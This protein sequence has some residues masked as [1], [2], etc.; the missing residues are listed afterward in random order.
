MVP[1][2]AKAADYE[3][4]FKFYKFNNAMPSTV[5][6]FTQYKSGIEEEITDL[7]TLSP[8]DIVVVSPVLKLKDGASASANSISIYF[9]YD[10]T[11]FNTSSKLPYLQF[12][13]RSVMTAEN[14]IFP[15]DT[16][17]WL[18]N[19]ASD[20]FTID[21]AGG[22][23]TITLRDKGM[24]VPY[25]YTGERGFAFFFLKLKKAQTH[26]KLHLHLLLKQTL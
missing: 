25:N 13:S 9:R 11:V 24:T 19:W 18:E 1:I 20:I 21:T 5:P 4:S 17:T 15:Y 8:G 22:T 23:A 7:S 14:A 3:A 26:L 2:D 16:A 12:D 10:N 6:W